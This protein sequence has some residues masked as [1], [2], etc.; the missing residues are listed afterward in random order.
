MDFV[1]SLTPLSKEH[2]EERVLSFS[3]TLKDKFH[4]IFSYPRR[5]RDHSG[6]KCDLVQFFV[7]C[8]D[9]RFFSLLRKA[10]E[11]LVSEDLMTLPP[12]QSFPSVSTVSP[13]I[14]KLPD[15][16]DSL[17]S[18]ELFHSFDKQQVGKEEVPKKPVKEVP[19]LAQFV[20]SR[21]K[22]S[23]Q[24]RRTRPKR[25]IKKYKLKNVIKPQA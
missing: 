12:V 3:D 13:T 11:H 9:S 10:L 16:S 17:S 8:G 20:S 2:F 19:S 21:L 24:E 25:K 18:C 23:N 7:H 14:S 6:S 15:S 4:V 22:P 5:I 1:L